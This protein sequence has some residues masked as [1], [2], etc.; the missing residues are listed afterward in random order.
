VLVEQWDQYAVSETQFK[1][2]LTLLQREA[3][4][5]D[6]FD[7]LELNLRSA[8]GFPSRYAVLTVDDGRECAMRVAD[9]LGKCGCHASFFLIRDRSASTPGYI[10]QKDIRELRKRGFSVGTHGTT[11]RKLTF[12]PE[13]QCLAELR[14]S[15]RWLEDVIGEE[16]RYM[17]A[18]GGFINARVMKSAYECGYTLVGTCNEWTNSPGKMALPCTVNRVNIRRHFTLADFRGMVENDLGF[19]LRQQI[20]HG[21]LWLPKQIL[22]R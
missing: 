4:V 15:K 17:A 18:P 9:L 1:D 2:Q 12:L 6:G 13:E 7:G 16:V 8:Q 14:E 3:Y 10:R 21:L 5:I 19:Y 22:Y 20:R 11:H